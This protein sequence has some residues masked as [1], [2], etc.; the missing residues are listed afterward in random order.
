MGGRKAFSLVMT[1]LCYRYEVIYFA[2][3]PFR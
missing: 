3:E 1:L 2:F